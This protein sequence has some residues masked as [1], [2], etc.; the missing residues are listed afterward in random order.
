VIRIKKSI[1]KNKKVNSPPN[2]F[3][4]YVKPVKWHFGIHRG[5]HLI[6]LY[7]SIA[8]DLAIIDIDMHSNYKNY[9]SFKL[10]TL[11]YSH[12]KYRRFVITNNTQKQVMMQRVPL[13]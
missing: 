13:V 4:A 9:N 12:W 10:C 6:Y 3:L 5:I 11:W 2:F 1:R 7:V 8:H